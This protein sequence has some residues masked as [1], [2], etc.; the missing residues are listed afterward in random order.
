MRLITLKTA[1]RGYPESTLG[2]RVFTTEQQH[3]VVPVQQHYPGSMP[4]DHMFR[5]IR[6]GED[7][8]RKKKPRQ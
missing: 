8:R 5:R 2:R 1:A 4:I 7:C 6:H 3:P